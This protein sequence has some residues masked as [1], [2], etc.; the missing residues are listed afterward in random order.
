[1]TIK[2]SFFDIT[3]SNNITFPISLKLIQ[4]NLNEL[5]LIEIIE[6]Y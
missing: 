2:S 4:V 5:K 1:M 6:I 3:N